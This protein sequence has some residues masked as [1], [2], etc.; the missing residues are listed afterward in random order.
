MSSYVKFLV[1]FLSALIRLCQ[2]SPFHTGDDPAVI[3]SKRKQELW[4]FPVA[5]LHLY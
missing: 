2:F 1:S 3:Q 5:F 4:R